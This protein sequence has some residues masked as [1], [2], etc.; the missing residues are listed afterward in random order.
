MK[1]NIHVT[2]RQFLKTSL[3]GA[4][5][6]SMMP[7]IIP[8]SVL[9]GQAAG[10]DPERLQRILDQFD[11]NLKTWKKKN[12]RKKIRSH[13]LPPELTE[14]EATKLLHVSAI[15]AVHNARAYCRGFDRLTASQQMALSQLVRSEEHTSELQS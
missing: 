12:Y 6:A 3:A 14:E 7:T 15:Q 5:G 10:L 8:S 13:K 2:R 11:R 4:A 9:L 1:Q